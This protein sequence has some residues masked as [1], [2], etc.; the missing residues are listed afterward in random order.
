MR[1]FDPSGTI[2]FDVDPSSM[3]VQ[4]PPYMYPESRWDRPRAK[5][6]PFHGGSLDTQKEWERS[7]LCCFHIQGRCQYGDACRFSHD[8]DG[9]RPCQF[10]GNCKQGH[11]NRGGEANGG[12][13]AVPPPAAPPAPAS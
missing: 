3:P 12:A 8:D 5:K 11:S 9:I 13:P 10:E 4:Y 1:M 2:Y 6:R 7:R